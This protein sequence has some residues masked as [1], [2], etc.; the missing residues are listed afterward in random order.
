M[1]KTI[2]ILF[3]LY[4]TSLSV[5]AQDVLANFSY[6]AHEKSMTLNYDRIERSSWNKYF[7]TQAKTLK[8]G[9]QKNK[10]LFTPEYTTS[11]ARVLFAVNQKGEI[12]SYKIKS[13]CIPSRDEIFINQLKQTINSIEKFDRLPSDYRYDFIIFT[14]KF[15][16]T[17]PKDLNTAKIDWQRYGFADIE[18]DNHNT[19]IILK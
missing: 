13:S 8:K 11:F 4:L 14:A 16:S 9:W 1:K 5:Y 3:L 12:I 17:L 18:I 19:N 15:H 10:G 2:L 7:K 6:A